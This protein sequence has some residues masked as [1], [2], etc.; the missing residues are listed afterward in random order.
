[1]PISHFVNCVVG[2]V[3]RMTQDSSLTVGGDP[4]ESRVSRLSLGVLAVAETIL[5]VIQLFDRRV[6]GQIPFHNSVL[7]QGHLHARVAQWTLEVNAVDDPMDTHVHRIGRQDAVLQ[8][9]A[10]L[11]LETRILLDGVRGVRQRLTVSG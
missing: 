8:A 6:S 1:M 5:D 11:R 4:Y 3:A 7:A 10:R 2:P 9:A